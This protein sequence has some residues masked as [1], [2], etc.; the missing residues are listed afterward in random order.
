MSRITHDVCLFLL[1]IVCTFS[2]LAQQV[3][4]SPGSSAVVVP[5]LV[6]F[7][8]VLPEVDGKALSA[9]VGV[10]RAIVPRKYSLHRHIA[11]DATDRRH[12]ALWRVD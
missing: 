10:I 12:L 7:S 3:S 9:V 6:N 8:G 2:A 11:A 1:L 4:M 5:S